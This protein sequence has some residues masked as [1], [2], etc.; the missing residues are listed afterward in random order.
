MREVD[1]SS[2]ASNDKTILISVHLDDSL[3]FGVYIDI[4]IDNVIRKSR[5]DF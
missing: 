3:L 1:Q 5:T 4:F 2:F